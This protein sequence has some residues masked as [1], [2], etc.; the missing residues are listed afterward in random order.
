[1]TTSHHTSPARSPMLRLHASDNVVVATRIVEKGEG[2]EGVVAGSR[3]P[4][5]HKMAAVA[6]APGEAVRKFGQI[7]GFAKGAIQPGDWVHEHNVVMGEL[8]HD[9]GFGRE[10]KQEPCC[11]NRSAPPLRATAAR[12][13][14]SAPATISAS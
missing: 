9:Y 6:I 12:T 7:I 2:V 13:A 5:G 4:R 8:S 11:R 10:A 14:R 3:I 1:M